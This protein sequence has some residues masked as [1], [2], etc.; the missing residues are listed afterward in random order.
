MKRIYNFRW[1]KVGVPYVLYG[2]IYFTAQNIT[3]TN[4]KRSH[5]HLNKVYDSFS[6]RLNEFVEQRGEKE[7]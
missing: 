1:L 6:S 2:N 5:V 7:P 3:C 4:Y